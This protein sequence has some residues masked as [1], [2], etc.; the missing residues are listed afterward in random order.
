MVAD[1]TGFIEPLNLE[2]LLINT[3]AGS[4]E[5][6]MFISIIVIAMIGAYFR[7]INW[8]MLVM[9]GL[10]AIFMGAYFEGIYFLVVLIT[11][12]ILAYIISKI[13]KN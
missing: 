7:M 12:L 3:F 1:C 4:M 13:V 6:F 5:I 2:C 10:F 8:I 9:F 11:G